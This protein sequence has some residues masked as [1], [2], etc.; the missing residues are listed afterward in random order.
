MIRS[1]GNDFQAYYGRD[2]REYETITNSSRF[3]AA[4]IAFCGFM[5]FYILLKNDFTSSKFAASKL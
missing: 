2:Q 3:L 1:V 4:K 5:A